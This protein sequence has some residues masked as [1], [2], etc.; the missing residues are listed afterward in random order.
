MEGERTGGQP[1]E[2]AVG[3]WVDARPV[4]QDGGQI[5][6]VLQRICQV[7]KLRQQPRRRVGDD[8]A[9]LGERA[10]VAVCTHAF[11]ISVKRSAIQ[12]AAQAEEQDSKLLIGLPVSRRPSRTC[13]LGSR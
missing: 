1:E 8:N 13:M 4:G 7:L 11:K 9:Y 2:E 3:S 6:R 12:N 10:E 5:Q